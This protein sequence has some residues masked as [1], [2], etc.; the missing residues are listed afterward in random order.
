LGFPQRHPQGSILSPLLFNIYL[1][2]VGSHIHSDSHILQYADDIVLFSSN[3]DISSARNFLS[4][5]LESISQFL[6]SLGLSLSPNKSKSIIFSRNQKFKD[7][8]VPFTIDGTQILVVEQVK[9]LG[10]ILDWKLNGTVHLKFLFD[11]GFRVANIVTS[12]SGVWWG[13]HPSLLLLIYRSVYRGAIEDK[14]QIYNLA[15]NR[16]LFLKMQRQQFRIIRS[17]LGFR[18]STPI[19]VL[20]SESCEPPLEYRFAL[21]TSKFIYKSFARNPFQPSAP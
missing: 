11:K 1:K 13:A 12:L 21:L 2:N 19:S 6:A 8:F 17:V 20:L 15:K 5:S 18:Q 16:S 9:F 3:E 7:P 4:L 14:A 10:V